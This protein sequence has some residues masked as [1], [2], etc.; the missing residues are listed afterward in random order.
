MRPRTLRVVAVM[1]LL[2]PL[3]G[4]FTGYFRDHMFAAVV[5]TAVYISIFFSL[6]RLARQRESEDSHPPEAQPPVL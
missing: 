4:L 2:L 1:F 5:Q 6:R 3:S